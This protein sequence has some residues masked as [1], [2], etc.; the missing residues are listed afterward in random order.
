M[1]VEIGTPSSVYP[2]PNPPDATDIAAFK[3]NVTAYIIEETL[4]SLESELNDSTVEVEEFLDDL[5][6]AS[7]CYLP[8]NA[9]LE[10]RIDEIMASDMD[11]MTE[12]MFSLLDV[13]AHLRW[14]LNWKTNIVL[15]TSPG[16]WVI[17]VTPRSVKL[18][19]GKE[20]R[21]EFCDITRS[22]NLYL[23]LSATVKQ[24]AADDALAYM[25]VGNDAGVELANFFVEDG[26]SLDKPQDKLQD[27]RTGQHQD[28]YDADDNTDEVM[29]SLKNE[30]DFYDDDDSPNNPSAKDYF[31]SPEKPKP[32]KTASPKQPGITPPTQDDSLRYLKNVQG[33]VLSIMEAAIPSDTQRE[34]IKTLI[35]KE[36]RREM[37]K[38]GKVQVGDDE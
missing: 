4:E 24:A 21:Q 23:G 36:F 14:V 31:E 5:Q 25:T 1:A 26:Q 3:S 10:K 7:L 15:E 13:S 17:T 34:A 35:K 2:T 20:L 9:T 16:K 6:E 32:T 11:A 29:L 38:I 33:R 27:R 12:S 8:D 28:E 18:H 30:S 37:S 22:T 19:Y